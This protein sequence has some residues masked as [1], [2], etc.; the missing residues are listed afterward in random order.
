MN[1]SRDI[2][3]KKK[4]L[5]VVRLQNQSLIFMLQNNSLYPE[6]IVYFAWFFNV[7][8]KQSAIRFS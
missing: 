1:I 5:P 7:L 6:Y 2:S 3:L 8:G 4:G